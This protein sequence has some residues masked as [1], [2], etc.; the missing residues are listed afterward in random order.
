M[1]CMKH[2]VAFSFFTG[3]FGSHRDGPTGSPVHYCTKLTVGLQKRKSLLPHTLEGETVGDTS[4]INSSK[5]K[6]AGLFQKKGNKLPSLNFGLSCTLHTSM[7]FFGNAGN[8]LSSLLWASYDHF[9]LFLSEAEE[10]DCLP[11]LLASGDQTWPA[12]WFL[13]DSLGRPRSSL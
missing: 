6:G 1:T 4:S 8:R 9:L 13:F 11:F 5:R 12:F 3:N 10:T 7:F 2:S